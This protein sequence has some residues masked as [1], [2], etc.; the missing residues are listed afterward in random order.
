MVDHQMPL[1]DPALFLTGQLAKN[2]A[3]VRPQLPIQRLAP[4]FRDEHDM[5]FAVPF[6]VT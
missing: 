4:L 3:K 2:F 1:F 5:V 6:C